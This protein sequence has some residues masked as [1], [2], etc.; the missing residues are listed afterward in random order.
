VEIYLHVFLTPALDG[1]SG[2]FTRPFIAKH[3][4]P[5]N[6][7]QSWWILGTMSFRWRKEII[8]SPKRHETHWWPTQYTDLGTQARFSTPSP[9]LSP[10]V[11][12]L[13]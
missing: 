9:V 3:N 7:R 4:A 8:L 11:L 13:F 12:Q 10:I 2:E 5:T 6:I 1:V